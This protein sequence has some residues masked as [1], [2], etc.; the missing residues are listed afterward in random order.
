MVMAAR[1]KNKIKASLGRRIF[2]FFNYTFFAI[3][4]FAMLAPILNLIAKSV[5]SEAAVLSGEVG[6]L[7]NFKKLQFDTYRIVIENKSFIIGLKNTVLVT[8]LG[9]FS[10][11]FVTA[12]AAY[13]LSKEYLRARKV[14]IVLCIFIMI[15]S[16]GLIPTYMVVDKLRL[17]NTFTVLWILGVFNVYNM[18]IL[19]SNFESISSE[20][21]ESAMIDGAGHLTIFFKIYLPLTKATLAVITLFSAVGYW[22][23]FFTSLIYTSKPQLKTL[24]LVLK[25]IIFSVSDIFLNLYGGQ[26][27]GEVTAQS[28]V[29]ACVVVATVPILLV[30][31]FLQ[32]H[33]T[34]G[35]M[36]GAVKG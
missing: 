22:N 23:N 10:S 6:L 1:K 27:A 33:F 9:S 5:S 19:K 31:P 32:K 20:L 8:I 12:C 13:A 16:G 30:Y 21:E 11:L 24:Q 4:A 3:L 7:P 28:T 15:F 2:C 29:A 26:S 25:E 36:T 18:L 34:K 17:T 35:V 14:L